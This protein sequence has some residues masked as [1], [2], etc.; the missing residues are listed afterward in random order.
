M[1]MNHN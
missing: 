1:Q